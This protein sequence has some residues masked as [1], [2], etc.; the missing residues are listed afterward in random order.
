MDIQFFEIQFFDAR[1]VLEK[2]QVEAIQKAMEGGPMG[3]K[4]GPMG[5][6]EG[7]KEGAQ[8]KGDHIH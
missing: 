6:K 2:D 8:R 7:P 1:G 5:P 3:P 4:G